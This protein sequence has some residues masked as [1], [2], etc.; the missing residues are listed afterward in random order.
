MLATVECT[1]TQKKCARER[2][3]RVF[4]CCGPLTLAVD[5]GGWFVPC[6]FVSKQPIHLTEK[7]EPE[8]T[9]TTLVGCPTYR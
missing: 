6:V 5:A 8:K 7:R 4:F 2:V 9:H 1:H 3:A